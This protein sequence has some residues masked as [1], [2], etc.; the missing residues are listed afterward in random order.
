M[1]VH[2]YLDR[3]A[4]SLPDTV[5]LVSGERRLTYGELQLR[6]AGFRNWLLSRGLKKGDRVAIYLENTPECVVAIFGALGAGGCLVILNP[7]TVLSRLQYILQDSG[8]SFLIVPGEKA[9][10][11]QKAM[12]APDAITIV[13]VEGSAPLPDGVHQFAAATLSGNPDPFLINGNDLAAIIY[14]S[15]ST[16]Q[17]KGATHLHRTVDAAVESIIEYLG[18]SEQDVI[19]SFLPLSSSYGILQLLCTFRTGARLVLE[20]GFGFPYE[21]VQ[22]IQTE[23]VTGMAGA[24][25]VW[26][27]LTKL[28]GVSPSAFESMRY[29]TNAAAALPATFIPRLRRMFPQ[30]RIFLMHGATECFRTTFLPPEEV[31]TRP[32]SVGRGMP[33]IELWLEDADGRRLPLGEEGEM[34]ARGPSVMVGYW[35]NAG[36]TA[37]VLT[38]GVYPWEQ[39]FH[40]GDTFRT[41]LEGYFYFVARKDEIIKSRGEKVSPVEVEDVIYK[42]EQV[43]EVRVVGVPDP[44]LGHAIRAEIVWKGEPTMTPHD[45]KVHCRKYLED[46]KTPTMVEFVKHLP[47]TAGGKIKRTITP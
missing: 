9:A 38:P 24:P 12:P 25:T 44:I 18:N 4:R 13:A 2:D 45:V 32:T 22:K 11:I 34:V 8:A 28:E 46:F 17:P 31:E 37:R 23:R 29:I 15:G 1:L 42:I 7:A 33:N 21:V 39:T 36:A 47:K 3:T 6:A 35:G 19:L 30:T 10:E 14:T 40:T 43:A 16:G 27:L 26:A 20:K 41:D 5:A